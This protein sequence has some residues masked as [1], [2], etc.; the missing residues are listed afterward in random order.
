MLPNST[1]RAITIAGIPQS[2]IECVKQICVVMLEVSPQAHAGGGGDSGDRGADLYLVRLELVE[3][4]K[5][6]ISIGV[7]KMVP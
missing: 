1:E 3:A 5:R 4:V 6:L 7:G 2:I